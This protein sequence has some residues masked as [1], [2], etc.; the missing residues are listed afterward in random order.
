MLKK[1]FTLAEVLITLAILGVI[2]ALTLP[3]LNTN[4]NDT[5]LEKQILKFYS[6]LTDAVDL[7]KAQHEVD[8]LASGL[9]LNE[10]IGLMNTGGHAT[11]GD[12]GTTYTNIDRTTVDN[13][14]TAL[15]AEENPPVY[16][17]PDGSV[18]SIEASDNM[19]KV[20]VDVN[21]IRTPNRLGED[22]LTMYIRRDGK[23]GTKFAN[24]STDTYAGNC[25]ADDAHSG[26]IGVMIANRF[27]MRN[28]RN[29]LADASAN[30]DDGSGNGNG[31]GTGTGA[32]AGGGISGGKVGDGRIINRG[33]E[34]IEQAMKK[35]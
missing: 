2:A 31:N 12:V 32:N 26:C 14:F 13:P 4:V 3:A 29:A 35:N 18:F 20:T 9:N 6:Q 17:L 34:S 15:L 33:S 22:T 27:N 5:V 19:W 11:S 24:R 21:G 8:T 1:G 25:K 23:V 30:S 10:F 28:Y 7:Y 16:N